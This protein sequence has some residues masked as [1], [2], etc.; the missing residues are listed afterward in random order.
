VQWSDITTALAALAQENDQQGTYTFVNNPDFSAYLPRITEQAERRMYR[1]CPFLSMRAQS[2]NQQF[3]AG[4]RTLPL[5]GM[6]PIPV[7]V[8]GLSAIYPAGVTPQQGTKREFQKASLDFIDMVWP[9]EAT[10][11]D[12][13]TTDSLYWAMYDHQTIVTAPTMNA[14]YTALVT[15]LFQPTPIGP[16]NA[17]PNPAT[18]FAGTQITTYL[19]TVY[20][21][22]FIAAC[23]ISTAGYKRDYG[24]Q[25]DDPKLAVSWTEQYRSLLPGVIE[26]EKRRR[27]IGQ[28][29]SQFQAPQNPMPQKG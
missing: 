8:E 13:S 5:L 12:P 21:D 2:A 20:P 23:M 1:D 16:T 3:Q 11:L 6:V 26:E 14:A 18:G 4:S 27:G 25:S 10:T 22:V 9:T 7:V 28:G 24:A 29:W 19:A 15:G 17:A